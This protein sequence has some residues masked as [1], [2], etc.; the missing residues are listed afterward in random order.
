MTP[1]RLR[2]LGQPRGGSA[3]RR[4][5][6]VDAESVTVAAPAAPARRGEVTAETVRRAAE[7]YGV[8]F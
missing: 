1:A 6:G 4:H 8:R 2:P 5:F 7:R 3:A